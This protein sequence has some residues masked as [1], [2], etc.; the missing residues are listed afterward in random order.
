[1][2]F[3]ILCIV[4]FGIFFLLY[5]YKSDIYIKFACIR[6]DISDAEYFL[7]TDNEGNSE[8]SEKAIESYHSRHKMLFK[9]LKGTKMSFKAEQFDSN[10]IGNDYKCADENVIVNL[11]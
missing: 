9:F 10:Y 3:I 8:V 6:C 1:M 4:S 2:I 7:V 11:F 5:L